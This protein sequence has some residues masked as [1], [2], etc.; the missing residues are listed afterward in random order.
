MSCVPVE[1]VRGATGCRPAG[2]GGRQPCTLPVYTPHQTATPVDNRLIYLDWNVQSNTNPFYCDLLQHI[3]GIWVRANCLQI[4]SKWKH[5][6]KETFIAWWS[7]L[8]IKQSMPGLPSNAD[9][10][11]CLT[12]KSIRDIFQY[13]WLVFVTVCCVYSFSNS[14][15]TGIY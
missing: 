12:H 2:W 14:V 5:I 6:G 10:V 3:S 1:T 13:C 8:L 7:V 11:E 15:A 9:N 4:Q